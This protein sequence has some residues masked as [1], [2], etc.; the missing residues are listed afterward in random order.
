[1]FMKRTMMVLA[2]GLVV[3]ITT[4]VLEAGVVFSDSFDSGTF[5]LWTVG[6]RRWGS[7]AANVVELH[8]SLM[9]HLYQGSF[10]ET[11][12]DKKLDY[13]PNMA[14]SFDMEVHAA[15]NASSTSAFHSIGSVYFSFLDFEDNSLGWVGYGYSTSSYYYDLY[16]PYPEFEAFQIPDQGLHSYS[17]TADGILSNITI[18]TG[19]ISSVDVQFYA[20]VTGY[21]YTMWADMWVDNVEITGEASVIPAPAAILLSALGLGCVRCLRRRRVF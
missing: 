5:D 1:M 21:G 20:A 16:N 18:D 9:G 4:G 19:S 2:A 14:F 6:G 12:I 7:S 15:S 17:L 10:T 8:G 3:S 13:V 11:M